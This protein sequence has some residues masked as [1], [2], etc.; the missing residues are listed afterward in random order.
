MSGTAIGIAVGV[1]I[2][3]LFLYLSLLWMSK[4]SLLDEY[5]AKLLA[6]EQ[7]EANGAESG[8]ADRDCASRQQTIREPAL[9]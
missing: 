3:A 2:W 9:Q 8:T 5:L 6:K 4:R 1:L 7:V